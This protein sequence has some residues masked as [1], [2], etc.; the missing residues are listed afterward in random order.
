[1]DLPDYTG[2]LDYL[3]GIVQGAQNQEPGTRH[4]EAEVND[5]GRSVHIYSY[6]GTEE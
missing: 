6:A 5:K 4:E 3:V 1:M 2:R